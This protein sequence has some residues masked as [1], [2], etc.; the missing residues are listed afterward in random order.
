MRLA[1]TD[2]LAAILSLEESGFEHGRW[3]EASWLEELERTAAAG[4]G[5]V[6]VERPEHAVDL[7]RPGHVVDVE[8]DEHPVD[9]ERSEHVVGVERRDHAVWVEEDERGRPIAVSSVALGG[10]VVDLLRV[11]VA[12]SSRRRGLGRDL[13]DQALRWARSHGAQRVLLEVA[14]SNVAAVR[15]YEGCGFAV[16][17]RRQGYYGDADALVMERGVGHG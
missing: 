16:I 4:A 11:V 2:D 3:S 12:P 1:T 7:E 15:L 14:E 10:D 6:D 8:G 9:L 13:V 5:R 17:A